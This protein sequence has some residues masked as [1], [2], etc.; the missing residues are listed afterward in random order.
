MIK[1]A[2]T[3]K[4]IEAEIN[5]SGNKEAADVYTAFCEELQKN[6]PKKAILKSLWSGI[7]SALPALNKLTDVVLKIMKMF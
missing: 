6:E 7:I 3:L 2:L 4:K 1:T 5:N